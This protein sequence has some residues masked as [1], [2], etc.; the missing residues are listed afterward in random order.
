MTNIGNIWSSK[1]QFST[2]VTCR[3]YTSSKLSGGG[4]VRGTQRS[5][6]C[7]KYGVR[8]TLK[9][10]PQRAGSTQGQ[11]ASGRSENKSYE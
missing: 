2:E 8:K 10:I 5:H 1:H 9:D 7:G 6:R 3:A 4:R 11:V